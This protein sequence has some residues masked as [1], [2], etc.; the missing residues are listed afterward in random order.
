MPIHLNSVRR[1]FQIYSVVLA[2]RIY[3]YSASIEH[4]SGIIRNQRSYGIATSQL[5]PPIHTFVPPL[6]ATDI[7]GMSLFAVSN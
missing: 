3:T 2:Y 7:P 6:F 4:I 1:D 5:S